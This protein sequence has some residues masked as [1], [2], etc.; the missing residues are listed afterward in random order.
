MKR[1][2]ALLIAVILAV[3]SYVSVSA[4]SIE[5]EEDMYNQI[6]D[7]TVYINDNEVQFFTYN[8]SKNHTW[9]TSF[10]SASGDANSAMIYAKDC[11]DKPYVLP[12]MSGSEYRVGMFGESGGSGYQ[13][14]SYD[15]T[16]GIYQKV[17]YKL[18]Q[19]GDFNEDGSYTGDKY[20]YRFGDDQTEGQNWYSSGLIFYSGGAVTFAAPDEDGY[21]EFYVSTDI[22]VDTTFTYHTLYSIDTNTSS[23]SG[24]DGSDEVLVI[25]FM[26]GYVSMASM[27]VSIFDATHIQKYIAKMEQLSEIKKFC[28]DVNVD[29]EV[30]IMDTT[31]IQFYLAKIE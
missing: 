19:C 5:F 29:G 12:V 9:A 11:V 15:T 4:E 31:A 18:S 23:T 21:V 30:N 24:S 16:G 10:Y 25:D 2:S 1:I 27:V 28:A 22:E 8:I 13:Y 17:R 20:T 26:K 7:E 6:L 3:T 14:F